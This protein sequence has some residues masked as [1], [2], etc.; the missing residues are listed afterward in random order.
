MIIKKFTPL[1]VAAL[2]MACSRESV[3]QNEALD[4]TGAGQ[5]VYEYVLDNGVVTTSPT[6]RTKG[7]IATYGN[8][9]TYESTMS[10]I[11]VGVYQGGVLVSDYVPGISPALKLKKTL[12]YNAYA[13]TAVG[14]TWTWPS[15]ESDLASKTIGVRS[16]LSA[17]ASK[18]IPCYGEL[19][20]LRPEQADL[21]DGSAD[22]NI[23]IEVRRLFAKVELDIVTPSGELNPYS[24]A[25]SD[26]RVRRINSVLCPF[27]GG[28]AA[29]DPSD[30]RDASSGNGTDHT[31]S[32]ETS[33]TMVFY[34]PEN[35][36]GSP[37]T[38][39]SD[40]YL[41][42][43]GSIDDAVGGVKSQLCTYLEVNCS[44]EAVSAF[45]SEYGAGQVSGA[46]AY[47]FLLGGDN[48]SDCNV[49]GGRVYRVTLTLRKKGLDLVGNW[50]VDNTDM[51]DFRLFGWNFYQWKVRPGGTAY[52]TARYGT[53]STIKSDFHAPGWGAVWGFDAGSKTQ[54]ETYV[55]SGSAVGLAHAHGVNVT[56]PECGYIYR[57]FPDGGN[58]DLLRLGQDGV[59]DLQRQWVSDNF[60][61]EDGAHLVCRYCTDTPYRF[62]P[63]QSSPSTLPYVDV[64][65]KSWA[66]GGADDFLW[67]P[68]PSATPSGSDYPVYGGSGDGRVTDRIDI[69]VG[70]DTPVL[71]DLSTLPRYV[72]Q[73]GTVTATRLPSGTSGVTFSVDGQSVPGML[74]VSD[75]SPSSANVSCTVKAMRSGSATVKVCDKATGDELGSFVL[76]VAAPVIKYEG[77]VSDTHW[78]VPD[79]TARNLPAH[80]ETTDRQAMTVAATDAEGF[81]LKF[82]PTLYASSLGDVA[83]VAGTH[84]DAPLLGFDGRYVFLRY[85]EN[86]GRTAVFNT[87]MPDAVR[88]SSGLCPDVATVSLIAGIRKPVEGYLGDDIIIDDWTLMEELGWSASVTASKAWRARAG[89]SILLPGQH[90]SIG[91]SDITT[92]VAADNMSV[93][94]ANSGL[95]DGMVNGTP[96][97]DNIEST[98]SSS[99]KVTV[100]MSSGGYSKGVGQFDLS[101]Y[102]RNFRSNQYHATKIGSIKIYLHTVI[103]GWCEVYGASS[104]SWGGSSYGA[105]TMVYIYPLGYWKVPDAFNNMLE[106]CMDLD[107]EIYDL[108]NGAPTFMPVKGSRFSVE[109]VWPGEVNWIPTGGVY[110]IYLHRTSGSVDNNNISYGDYK[111]A[112]YDY[113]RPRIGIVRENVTRTGYQDFLKQFP[114]NSNIWYYAIGGM[115]DADNDDL[116]YYVFQFFKDFEPSSNGWYDAGRF[117]LEPPGGR[118]RP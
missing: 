79:G 67:V 113:H 20:G 13:V 41:K 104:Y 32:G 51:D 66:G 72:A 50:K 24:I 22:G 55:A 31:V 112:I 89:S 62:F 19:K 96:Y 61:V 11:H 116:G 56:C 25:P 101:F 105:S 99:G 68:V 6:V 45:V 16:D 1:F 48:L 75:A 42:T 92:P 35:L 39:N 60:V 28:C 70:D 27:A 118:T 103:G 114:A 9:S 12:E 95:V 76:S 106:A 117:M 100:S 78:L 29:L 97:Y 33:G 7:V 53:S 30:V 98:V 43:P 109:Y 71:L 93:S 37:L 46:L 73:Q 10:E 15:S 18:G 58:G 77:N 81:G 110:E 90:L 5:D 87:A 2:T 65:T 38:W 23:C 17:Y 8:T 14:D 86:G 57:A 88:L 59:R 115:Q 44:A 85:F 83:A 21:A 69:Q 107:Q 40:S 47:R 80:Y 91:S 64:G 54:Y 52:L 94:L 74:E 26:V 108:I 82:A 49:E 84:A 111:Q 3:P 63:G 102:V 34:V 4:V 36:Q